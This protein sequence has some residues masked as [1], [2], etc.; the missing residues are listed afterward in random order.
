MDRNVFMWYGHVE[1]V[2]EERV[3]KRVHRTKERV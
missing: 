3:I 2:E 1:I